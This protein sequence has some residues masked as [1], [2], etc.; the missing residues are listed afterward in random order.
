M[1]A[2]TGASGWGYVRPQMLGM[3]I[4]PLFGNKPRE[5]RWSWCS[6]S[7]LHVEYYLTG[8]LRLAAG[9]ETPEQ[10]GATQQDIAPVAKLSEFD[11]HSLDFGVLLQAVLS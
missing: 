5:G 6:R 2:L 10:L 9:F 3:F 11:N 1:P 4:L 7:R 8:R